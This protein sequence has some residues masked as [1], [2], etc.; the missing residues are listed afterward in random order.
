MLATQV[1][2]RPEAPDDGISRGLRLT[3]SAQA[4]ILLGVV[5]LTGWLVNASAVG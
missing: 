1:R 4:V 2:Q 3:A 5:W